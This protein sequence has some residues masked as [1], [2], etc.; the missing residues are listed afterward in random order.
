MSGPEFN[1][2]HSVDYGALDEV[3]PLIRRVTAKNPSHF[4]FMGSGT[5]I[6]GRGNVAVIDPGPD[7]EAHIDALVANLEGETITHILIT[8]THSDHS[9]GTRR[10]LEHCDATV[11][12]F[13]PKVVKV[14]PEAY[15]E[16]F[17]DDFP[18]EK[19]EKKDAEAADGDGDGD[20]S[21]EPE[22]ETIE[23]EFAPDE[24]VS[25]GDVIEGDGFTF[26]A[27]HTPG[28]ISNHLSFGFHE[29]PGVFTG[30]H[31][32][33]WSTT[34]IPAPDGSLTEY[35]DSLQLL[36]DRGADET[37]WPTHG[38]PIT[39]PQAF[40]A[41]LRDHRNMRTE[42]VLSCLGEGMTSIR[43]M[44]T[45]MYSDKPTKLHRPA[46]LSVLSHLLHLHDVGTVT[47][48][49]AKADDGSPLPT[50]AWSLT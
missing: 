40:A 8:H 45:A 37:H 34:V 39:R 25:H 3:S 42:Q 33:G 44:V 41:A 16:G 50:S 43:E 1:L 47:A 5:Y 18:E 24:I 6:V 23:Y 17:F 11:F 4:T 28:H 14:P 12:G 15:F 36:V 20:K 35:L 38:A 7:D 32:M 21:D 26:D 31:I 19:D 49:G 29:E 2:E 22:R 30:D 10:L 9:P 27:L 48:D 13:D 46:A